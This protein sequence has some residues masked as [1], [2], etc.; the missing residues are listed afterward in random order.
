A[1]VITA[2]VLYPFIL[3]DSNLLPYQVYQRLGYA[4]YITGAGTIVTLASGVLFV[5]HLFF[6]V[7]F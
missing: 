3:L 5:F 4:Y 1:A 7:Y 2:V 6:T